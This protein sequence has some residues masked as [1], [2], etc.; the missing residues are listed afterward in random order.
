MTAASKRRMQTA[1]RIH[2]AAIQLAER[3]GL[4]NL[5]TEAIAREAGVSPRTFFNYYPYKEAAIAGPPKDYPQ[6]ASDDF[7]ASKG[8]LI[9][10]LAVLI[11]AHLSRFVD[12]RQQFATVLRLAETDAK[13]AALEQSAL[14]ERH[15]LME[16]MLRK[17]LSS[18][19]ARLAPILAAAIIS[20]TRQAV[21][22]WAAG[23]S[24]DLVALAIENIG[25]IG[26]AGD[27]LSQKPVA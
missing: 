14:L 13:L 9:D 21:L 19:D 4:S 22:E 27:L 7:V 6:V 25:M 17:R 11:A 24:D 18:H 23:R 2:V 3:D 12:Q 5:T 15:S 8:R 1:S 26:D 20:A 16:Q 10:D